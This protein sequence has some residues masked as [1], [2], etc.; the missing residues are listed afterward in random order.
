MNDSKDLSQP[1]CVQNAKSDNCVNIL[2]IHL[3]PYWPKT[4]H[5]LR[6][7]LIREKELER[8]DDGSLMKRILWPVSVFTELS[9][10]CSV[11]LHDNNV[12]VWGINFQ[13]V[14]KGVQIEITRSIFTLC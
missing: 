7:D 10:Q 13:T 12:C 9:A 4:L 2:H 11:P 8:D 3:M 14:C 1:F 5:C 6:Y